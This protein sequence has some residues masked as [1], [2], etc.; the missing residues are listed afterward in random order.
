MTV[1]L[2]AQ[3]NDNALGFT[4]SFDPARLHFVGAS[5]TGKLSK[6]M[7]L[8]NSTKAASGLLGLALALPAG[9]V[10]PA[11]KQPVVEL[12]FQA[13]PTAKSGKTT[14]TFNDDIVKGELT[15]AKATTQP[16]SFQNGVVLINGKGK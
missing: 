1:N 4:L 15:D 13:L 8:L 7:L 9:T 2:D 6:G 14:L 10:L 11:G 16:I 12:I 3:G 5:L